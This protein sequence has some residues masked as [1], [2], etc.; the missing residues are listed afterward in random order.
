MH[1][2]V[3]AETGEMGEHGVGSIS[4]AINTD[5]WAEVQHCPGGLG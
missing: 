2:G 5:E 1:L 4:A 3:R